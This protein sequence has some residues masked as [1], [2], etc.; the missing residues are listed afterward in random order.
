MIFLPFLNGNGGSPL[1]SCLFFLP[2]YVLFLLLPLKRCYCSRSPLWAAPIL[3]LFGWLNLPLRSAKNKRIV[4]VFY[5]SLIASFFAPSSLISLAPKSGCC[6]TPKNG[7]VSRVKRGFCWL[8]FLFLKSQWNWD[9]F[10]QNDFLLPFK[11][12]FKW[13]TSVCVFRS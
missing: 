12:G 7:H 10:A 13:I 5:A 4:S 11:T 8:C 9:S 2:F 3:A 1:E 6:H